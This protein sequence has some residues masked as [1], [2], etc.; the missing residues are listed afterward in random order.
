MRAEE[1]ELVLHSFFD[2]GKLNAVHIGKMAES[3]G[4]GLRRDFAA[5]G[6]LLE[7]ANALFW[8]VLCGWLAS[9]ATLRG[10]AAV[11]AGGAAASIEAAAASDRLEALEAALPP[12]V[13]EMVGVIARHADGGAAHRFATGQLMLLAAQCMDFADATGRGAALGMLERMLSAAPARC[14]AGR[15]LGVRLGGGRAKS[16]RPVHDAPLTRPFPC[17]RAATP[18]ARRLPPGQ[19]PGAARPGCRRWPCS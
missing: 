14:G 8:R 1:C 7:P 11:N 10:L 6:A 15:S 3:D 12:T 2:L 17:C 16:A 9:S 13:E 18:T 5:P 19:R 4:V